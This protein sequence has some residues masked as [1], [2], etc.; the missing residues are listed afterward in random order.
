MLQ[1]TG[2]SLATLKVEQTIFM[3]WNSYINVLNQSPKRKHVEEPD[4]LFVMAMKV[5]SQAPLS[6]IVCE[7]TLN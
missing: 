2:S 1:M 7:A 3:D 5:I 6:V 4:F